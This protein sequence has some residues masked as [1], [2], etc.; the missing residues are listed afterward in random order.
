MDRIFK[1]SIFL[2]IGVIILIILINST[3]SSEAAT[4]HVGSGQTYAK[5]QDAINNSNNGDTIFIHNGVY[6][7][8]LTIKKS[9]DLEGENRDLVKIDGKMNFATIDATYPQIRFN[10]TNLTI[11]NSSYCGILLTNPGNISNVNIT[12]TGFGIIAQDFQDL[13]I[14]NSTFYNNDFGIFIILWYS[15]NTF[16][17]YNNTIVNNQLGIIVRDILS[18]PVL[19]D[20]KIYNNILTNNLINVEN[21]VDRSYLNVENNW[22]GTTNDLIIRSYMEGLVDYRPYLT[23]PPSWYS[24]PFNITLDLGYLTKD[25]LK[26]LQGQI[27]NL[28][29]NINELK[30]NISDII[31]NDTSLK[32]RFNNI[33][34]E[35]EQL[36]T[37]IS[38]LESNNYTLNT[39]LTGILAE[40]DNLNGR[41]S[42]LELNDSQIIMKLDE[43]AQDILDLKNSNSNLSLDVQYL[44]NEITKINQNLNTQDVLLDQLINDINNLN[45][46]INDL[47]ND[48]SLLE[49]NNTNIV[50]DLTDVTV[51]LEGTL[52]ELDSLKLEN[53]LLNI[54]LQSL[55]N[56][57]SELIRSTDHNEQE[58]QEIKSDYNSIRLNQT[59]LLDILSNMENLTNANQDL[60]SDVDEL[61][62]KL[63]TNDTTIY[64]SNAILLVLI[65]FII[66]LLIYLVKKKNKPENN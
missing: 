41:I 44:N 37:D 65:L 57:L 66:I 49:L 24:E 26:Y 4:L 19:S 33:W 1:W 45:I 15:D 9:I 40:I 61:N 58:L 14:Y 32:S 59:N 48:L 51:Q 35:L 12:I 60:K 7:E 54:T 28:L 30:L 53:N 25:D 3:E 2:G 17:I 6:Y 64:I 20:Y 11:T 55:E 47:K 31:A 21:T 62:K 27:D 38:S 23:S 36:K 5:I 8:N 18:G 52:V 43:L 16:S 34:F 56:E 13:N 46:Q 63:N 42:K 22:F 50:N 39:K 29:D 10:I